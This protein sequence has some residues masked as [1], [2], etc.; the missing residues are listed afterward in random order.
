MI[1]SAALSDNY[2]PSFKKMYG[3]KLLKKLEEIHKCCIRKKVIGW[4]L[5]NYVL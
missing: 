5:I 4:K 2:I 1:V 3:K